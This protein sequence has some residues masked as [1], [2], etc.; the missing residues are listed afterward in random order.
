MT[1]GEIRG[2]LIQHFYDRRAE[3]GGVAPFGLT[4]SGLAKQFTYAELQRV[5]KQLQEKG[6]LKWAPMMTGGGDMAGHGRLTADGIDVAEGTKE[7]PITVIL[8]RNVSVSASQHV[9]IGDGNT[10]DVR[11]HV[12]AL[13]RAIDA[14]NGSAADKAEAKTRLA[15]LL[16]HPL[17]AAVAGAAAGAAITG[18]K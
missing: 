7:A 10:Q 17:V 13:V 11:V 16:E 4:A 18:L 14:S 5:C 1:E 8:N 12:E 9:Q 3:G 15:R 6:L 2:V